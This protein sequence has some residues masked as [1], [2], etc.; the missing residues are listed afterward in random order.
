MESTSKMGAADE[1]ADQEGCRF[2]DL[3]TDLIGSG[4]VGHALWVIDVG[5]DPPH[6]EGF[7]RIPH[8]TPR[9]GNVSGGFHHRVARMMTERQP[10]QGRDDIWV[11]P[12]WRPR[13]WRWDCRR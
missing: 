6:W 11:Y 5:H 4:P 1:G 3:G 10:L 2:L 7:G 9:T 12:C 8:M 13:W